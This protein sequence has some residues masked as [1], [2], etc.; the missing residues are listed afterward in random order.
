MSAPIS[1]HRRPALAVLLVILS[2]SAVLAKVNDL[3]VVGSFDGH[4]IGIIQAGTLKATASG[5]GMRRK[6]ADSPTL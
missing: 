1:F 2:A 5:S 4:G 3:S 6:S